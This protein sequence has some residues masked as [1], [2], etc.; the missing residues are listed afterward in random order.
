MIRRT[1]PRVV[2][3]AILVSLSV[4]IAFWKLSGSDRAKSNGPE[5]ISAEVSSDSSGL[6]G[7]IEGAGDRLD[8]NQDPAAKHAQTI[9]SPSRSSSSTNVSQAFVSGPLS[10]RFPKSRVLETRQIP[11]SSDQRFSVQHLVET[12]GKSRHLV[13]EQAFARST[14]G[15]QAEFVQETA[16]VADAILLR[17]D[18]PRVM[19]QLVA[20]SEILDY[21]KVGRRVYRARLPHATLAGVAQ[22]KARIERLMPKGMV[23]EA[24]YLL[25]TLDADERISH[26]DYDCDGLTDKELVGSMNVPLTTATLSPELIL[27]D[28]QERLANLPLGAR[29][30]TFDKPLSDLRPQF[31]YRPY[32]L[33]QNFLLVAAESPLNSGIYPQT[34]HAPG[35]PSNGTINVRSISGDAGMQIRH[36]D[37]LPFSIYQIDL[38]EYSIVVGPRPVTF[39]GRRTDG[40]TISQTFTLDGVMDGTGP[41]EDF[42]TF[43][44]PTGFSNL[45]RLTITT[46]GFMMDNLVVSLVGEETP[47]PP[48]PALPVLYDISWDGFPHKVGE[49]TAVTG[50]YAPSTLMFGNPYVRSQVGPMVGPAL[51]LRGSGATYEQFACFVDRAGKS[52]TLDFDMTMPSG[53]TLALFFDRS[54]GLSRIDFA[55][56]GAI[57]STFGFSG[58]FT[59]AAVTHFRFEVN[60]VNGTCRVLKNGT[61]VHSGAFPSSSAAGDIKGIRLSATVTA[62]QA[63]GIDNVRITGDVTDTPVPPGPYAVVAPL[64]LLFPKITSGMTVTREVCVENAGSAPL[65]IDN[66][67]TDLPEFRTTPNASFSLLPG[68]SANISVTY[69]PQAPGTHD[70]HLSFDTNEG[71]GT[72]KTVLLS[73]LATGTPRINLTPTTLHITMLESDVGTEFFKIHNTGT[74]TL[75]W[76]FVTRPASS[77]G[78]P[79][80]PN[81]DRFSSLWSMRSPSVN[82]GGIDAVRAWRIASDARAARVAVI[83]TGVDHTHPDLSANI[84]QN[85]DEIPGNGLDDDRNGF[86]DDVRGWNFFSDNAQPMDDHGHGTHVAGTIGA[87]GQNGVGVCGVAWGASI[88]PIKFLGPQGFGYTS[89]AIASVEYAQSIG[90]RIVNA[91]WG[92]GSYSSLL[93]DTIKDF[94]VSNDALFVTAAGNSFRN[95]DVQ[96]SFPACYEVAGI[97]SVAASDAS[98][99]LAGF[100]NWGPDSVDIAAP[101]VGVLSCLPN[102]S[103]GVASGTSMAAPHVSGSAALLLSY[104]P[105][106]TGAECFQRLTS[107]ADHPARLSEKVRQGSR[108]NVYLALSSSVSPWIR[109]SVWSGAVAASS[110]FT[111]PL[112]VDTHGLAAGE[113]TTSLALETNDPAQ[114][115]AEISVLLKVRKRNKLNEWATQQFAVNNLLFE[116]DAS[117]TWTASAD[118][119][120]D[121]NS[122]LLEFLTGTDPEKASAL[123][124]TVYSDSTL[125]RTFR[126]Q[127]RTDP[128]GTAYRVE[129]T[130]DLASND[131]R[132]S[133]LQIRLMPSGSDPSIQ[134][135]EA[136][137][138][139]AAT[140]PNLFFR[141]V[142]SDN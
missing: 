14:A 116:A 125:G 60:L 133:G 79:V 56:S 119:D 84:F 107:N 25:H 83:D 43:S 98:D 53:G 101:G 61:Q 122:N 85:V 92:G 21:R 47:L 28:V 139:A 33:E 94:T 141:I 130:S 59:P 78:L 63:I 17:P 129:W 18:D 6:T 109:P 127:T 20:S 64:R 120:R 69:A 91:S 19:D 50:P 3:T 135:W 72:T 103:Y 105:A 12:E 49:R 27:K 134:L 4:G 36:K 65:L 8:S 110:S 39:V 113:Y 55:S 38:A 7:S 95:N 26:H 5:N 71:A 112:S 68:Q 11:S 66:V 75:Q 88:I 45:D 37:G 44:F 15:A 117:D 24:D 67:R 108:L 89:D 51:E 58:S 10:H 115:L 23:V 97:I 128:S 124:V 22:A 111:V 137:V 142:A 46:E 90:C 80:T 132:T 114:P 16:Y 73:G 70:G 9:L 87:S 86:V 76:R 41:V 1:T 81:D 29:V 138:P 136:F 57:T 131:W 13:V 93:R 106:I 123:P 104:H 99:G 48:A 40:T 35:Y 100:S 52:Y 82:M 31:F 126:F 62:S 140:L 32:V 102:N 30:L 34:A 42:Q 2:V 118:P 54:S 96:P 77:P 121:G 74:D